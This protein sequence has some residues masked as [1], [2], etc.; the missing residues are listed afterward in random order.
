MF[1]LIYRRLVFDNLDGYVRVGIGAPF[2]YYIV[3]A[4]LETDFIFL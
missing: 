4:D 3:I 2:I 1:P